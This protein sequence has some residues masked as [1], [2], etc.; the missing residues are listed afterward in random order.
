MLFD[1]NILNLPRLITGTNS[2]LHFNYTYGGEKIKK[3]VIGDDAHTRL[4]L[5]G[6]EYKDGAFEAYYHGD[7]RVVESSTGGM[8]FQ[9]KITDHLGNTVV[10]F[11]DKDNDGLIVTESQTSDPSKIEVLE[12]NLYYPFGLTLEG[13]W[14]SETDPLHN[15]RYNGKE[16]HSEAELGWLDFGQ[17]HII[18]EKLA[19]GLLKKYLYI[20][21]KIKYNMFYI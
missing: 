8:Q 16:W 4:Y 5:N 20:S 12:R 13:V 18:R 1:Y 19:N 2:T 17:G 15:Y 9:Y 7:G 3:Q 21:S 6:V 14:N 11:E 10:L